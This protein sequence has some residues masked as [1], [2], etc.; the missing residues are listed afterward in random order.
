M[1]GPQTAQDE[2]HAY[3]QTVLVPVLELGSLI[4]LQ[5]RHPCFGL[6]TGLGSD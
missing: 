1:L 3:L 6:G 2:E 4:H 5:S